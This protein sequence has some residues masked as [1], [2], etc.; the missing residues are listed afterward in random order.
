MNRR[1]LTLH[2]A[3][4]GLCTLQVRAETADPAALDVRANVQGAGQ[5]DGALP[6]F[7]QVY[8]NGRDIGMVAAFTAYIGENRMSSARKELNAIGIATPYGLENREVFLDKLPGV[9]FRYDE[10]RQSID[11]LVD[12]ESLLPNVISAAQSSAELVPSR[13]T[14]AVLNYSAAAQFGGN[15]NLGLNVFSA[16]FDGWVYSAFGTLEANGFYTYQNGIGGR[17]VRQDTRFE[18]ADRQ[19]AITYAFGDV[20]SSSL[21]WSRP[22]RMGGFQLRRDFSLRTDIVSNQLLSFSGAAAVPST[23]D[24]FIENNRAFTASVPEGPFQLE[25]L[26]VYVGSGDA[27]IVIRDQAGRV[28][29]KS[30]SFFAAQDLMKPGVAD[31]SLEVGVAREAY[32][33]ESNAYGDDPMLSGSLRYGVNTWLTVEAHGEAKSDLAML[34]LGFSTVPFSLGEVSLSAGGSDYM[35]TRAGFA[36]GSLRTRVQGVDVNI[37]S[38]RTEKGFADLAYA[39]G[40]DYLGEGG[41]VN[42]AGLLEFPTALDV[43]SL[44][45]PIV[46]GRRL[47]VSVVRSERASSS[48]MIVAASY[49]FSFKDGTGGFSLSGSHNFESEESRVSLGFSMPL[50]NRSHLRAGVATDEQGNSTSGIYVSRPISDQLGDY[51]YGLQLEQQDGSN[52]AAAAR[53]QYRTRYGKAGVEVAANSGNPVLRGEFEG[54]VVIS[55]GQLAMGNAI[56]DSFAVVDV[57]IPDMPVYLQNRAVTRTG[58]GGRALVPGLS[59][60]RNNR[61]SIDVADLPPGSPSGVTAMDVVPARKAGSYVNFNAG[62][63]PSATIVLKAVSGALL[64]AGTEVYL[65]GSTAAY[66]VGYDGLTWV[67]GI[68]AGNRLTATLASGNCTATF[69]RPG[70]DAVAEPPVV[71]CQ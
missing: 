25:D 65:N 29:R 56:Q 54:A 34:G 19:H 48:D 37:S 9:I 49:G 41:V 46:N 21:D 70:A 64:P 45:I 44:S 39:T 32:G 43:V 27:E 13:E 52:I 53:G 31:Y 30:V 22:V 60:Y 63:V 16:T 42:D 23:V 67:E 7:L 15:G 59:S 11:F 28:V 38:M 51:G 2:V 1:N 20:I 62:A 33:I 47:G 55:G 61:V 18:A 12:P 17:F 69:P 58:P 8:I 68:K 40:V 14:G 6:L 24:V 4:I 5:A 71:I 66:F 26:P 36:R 50:G 3:L 35:G 57:G 10:S